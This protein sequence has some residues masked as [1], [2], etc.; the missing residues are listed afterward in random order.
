M[1]SGLV[2]TK[3]Q[4]YVP[5]KES[6]EEEITAAIVLFFLLIPRKRTPTSSLVPFCKN[7]HTI[8]RFSR[9][10]FFVSLKINVSTNL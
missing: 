1:V 2:Y 6:K 5:D 10:I 7:S 3:V 8:Q 9:E 4:R